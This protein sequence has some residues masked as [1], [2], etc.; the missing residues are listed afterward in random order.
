MEEVTD[1]MINQAMHV[2]KDWTSQQRECQSG[3]GELWPVT[4]RCSE[5]VEIANWKKTRGMVAA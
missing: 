3:R 5:S 1:V 4:R 2:D